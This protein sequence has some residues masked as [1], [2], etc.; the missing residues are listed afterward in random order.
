M[1]TGLQSKVVIVTGGASNIGKGIVLAFAKEGSKIVIVDI[2]E[3]QSQ[4]VAGKAKQ[5]GAADT[6][7]I[8]TDVT[9]L[10]E[11]DNMAR[12]VLKKFGNIDVLVNN[13]GW[14]APATFLDESREMLD[15]EININLYSTINCTKAIL[16]HMREMKHGKIVNISSEAA[17]A[18]DPQRPVYSACKGAVISLT[19][20]L[21][22]DM[23]SYGITVNCVCPHVIIPENEDDVGKGSMFHGLNV[24]QLHTP[25]EAQQAA[26]EGHA[27]KRVGRPADLAAAVVFLS[28]EAA[29][30][31]TGQ[32]LSVNGGDTMI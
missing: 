6:L 13:V 12:T 24:L 2:D 3:A 14:P 10:V 29:S 28:S 30:Y 1:E 15:K 5:L 9:N 20:A 4:K 8:K 23:G 32:T 16:P 17:R 22:R 26:T 19:K 27:L 31:I 7:V 18:G 25:S 11:V 21:A